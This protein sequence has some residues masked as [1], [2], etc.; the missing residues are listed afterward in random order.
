MPPAWVGHL[1]PVANSF[2]ERVSPFRT[3]RNGPRAALAQ[4]APGFRR[5]A[6]DSISWIMSNSRQISR[7]EASCEGHRWLDVRFERGAGEAPYSLSLRPEL[8]APRSG[9]SPAGGQFHREPNRNRAHQLSWL[10]KRQSAASGC[11]PLA[12]GPSFSPHCPLDSPECGGRAE[13]ASRC[14]ATSPDHRQDAHL[15]QFR[16]RRPSGHHGGQLWIGQR[17]LSSDSGL[18]L[19]HCA[20]SSAQGPV[21]VEC[22][23][24]Y[25]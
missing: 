9:R 1:E 15:D 25:S 4:P 14:R 10:E 11:A 5:A 18:T 17:G 22:L 3:E 13:G 19:A 24:I 12:R 7:A 8:S 16:Q 20:H 23:P 6:S 21:P 2:R